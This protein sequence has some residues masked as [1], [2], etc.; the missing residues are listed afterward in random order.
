MYI[1]NL[2]NLPLNIPGISCAFSKALS[3]FKK[4]LIFVFEYVTD[5]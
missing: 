2:T 5:S 4:S 1:D 3:V